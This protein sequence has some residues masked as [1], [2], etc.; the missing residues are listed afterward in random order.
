MK[1]PFSGLRLHV[2]AFIRATVSTKLQHVLKDK[3]VS[4][5]LNLAAKI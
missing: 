5:I 1:M 3:R 2:F 4:G